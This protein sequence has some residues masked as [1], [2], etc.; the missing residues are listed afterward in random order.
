M[1]TS[2]QLHKKSDTNYLSD[3]EMYTSDAENLPR[4]PATEGDSVEEG[5]NG[6]GIRSIETESKDEDPAATA[7]Y[8]EVK[9]KKGAHKVQSMCCDMSVLYC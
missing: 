2:F 5:S 4:G 1:P 7:Q 8:W 3:D 9:R 6:V